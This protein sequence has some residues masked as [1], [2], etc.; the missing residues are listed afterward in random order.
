MVKRSMIMVI[1]IKVSGK[2]IRKMDKA[3]YNIKMETFS[4]EN[5]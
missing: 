1:H 5:S 2:K 4:K 3:Y